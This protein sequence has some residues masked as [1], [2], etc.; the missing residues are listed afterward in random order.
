MNV[1]KKRGVAVTVLILAVIAA[2]LIGQLTKP[3]VDE[4]YKPESSATAQS[5]AKEHAGSYTAYVQDEA[6]LFSSATKQALAE[7]NA[8]LDYQYSGILGVVTVSTLGDS[9]IKAY[10]D[11][12][13]YGTDTYGNGDLVLLIDEES[14]QGYVS[15][16]DDISYYLND[17][18]EIIFTQ[19][20]GDSFW[21]DPDGAI[22]TLFTQVS[23]WYA[24]NVP[25]SGQAAQQAQTA[26]KSS[27]SGVG[28]II[29]LILVLFIIFVII[30]FV[31]SLIAG[32]RRAIGGY[33][34]FGPFW[35]PWWGGC[36]H[37]HPRWFGGFH[38]APPPPPHHGP[39][40]PGGGPRPP[41]N[42]PP[43]YNGGGRSG[44]GGGGSRGGFGGGGSRGGFGGGGSRGGFSGGGSRGGFGGGGSRGGFGGGG[45]RGG[46]GGGRR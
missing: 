43:R 5:W 4:T 6:G 19:N 17:N 31:F 39:G 15:P 33:G 45:S 10:S 34:F 23:G 1:F 29:V 24:K 38:G 46:F 11:K 26:Q 12:I 35:G 18:L 40:G 7:D 32:V 21:S 27:D 14:G 16:G 44:S 13:C 28:G 36:Y 41:R 37:R 30:S 25:V 42:D 2:I 22:T 9:T 8:A 20:L 3:S